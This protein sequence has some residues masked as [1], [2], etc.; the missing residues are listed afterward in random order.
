MLEKNYTNPEGIGRFSFSESGEYRAPYKGEGIGVFFTVMVALLLEAALVIFTL[1]LMHE[2]L[3][4]YEDENRAAMFV[5]MTSAIVIAVGSIIIFGV[6]GLITANIYSGM[7][8]KYSATEDTF[9]AIVGGDTH[10]IKY[11]QVQSITFSPKYF[12]GKVKGYDV[13]IMV[14][15][16]IEHFG[17]SFRGQYQTEKSTPFYIIKERLEIIERRRGD[18]MALYAQQKT[19]A[20]KPISRNEIDRARLK[21]QHESDIF[22][23]NSNNSGTV[24][25]ANTAQSVSTMDSIAPKAS[26]PKPA[27]AEA[28][29][30]EGA[31][32]ASMQ[33]PELKAKASSA[34]WASGNAQPVQPAENASGMSE[35]A[36]KNKLPSSEL[37]AAQNPDNPDNEEFV[38]EVKSLSENND[39]YEDAADI[40]NY[41]DYAD[42]ADFADVE[43]AVEAEAVDDIDDAVTDDA[44]KFIKSSVKPDDE[45]NETEKA[46]EVKKTNGM[47]GG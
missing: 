34:P 36:P 32:V 40:T 2:W 19:G 6:A 30:A 18:E 12:L 22:P 23:P 3:G 16:K 44:A 9:V 46:E 15:N 4:E 29:K 27:G 26:R 31:A 45:I 14:N 1:T 42:L 28:P 38:G 11:T 33:M 35:I 7:N 17:V 21:K 41:A 43:S 5:S 10:V 47:N 37:I 8:C 24:S 39:D 20:D 13:D 25:D